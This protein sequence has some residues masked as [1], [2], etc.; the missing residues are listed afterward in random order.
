MLGSKLFDIP[1][2]FAAIVSDEGSIPEGL[3]R[4]AQATAALTKLKLIWR[5]NNISLGSKVSLMHSIVISKFLYTCESWTMT[6]ELKERM[7]TFEMRCY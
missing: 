6:A 5:D 4:I 3:T 7:Q 1:S 2:Y